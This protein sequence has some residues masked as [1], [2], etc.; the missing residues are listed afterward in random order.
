VQIEKNLKILEWEILLAN[1]EFIAASKKTDNG[2][3]IRKDRSRWEIVQDLLKVTKEEKRAKK[4]RIMQRAYLDWRNF[5]R[6]FD[7][8]LEEGFIINCDSN[9]YKLTEKG[10]EL[11][12]RL[13]QVDEMLN[14]KF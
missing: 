14:R 11:I 10:E 7:F 4:T 8:L 6:Y 9:S 5:H 2:N 1:R 12:K 3:I 13:D